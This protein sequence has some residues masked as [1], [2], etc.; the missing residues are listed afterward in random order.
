MQKR[1]KGRPGHPVTYE[2]VQYAS[3]TEAAKAIGIN[4]HTL[5]YRLDRIE[6]LKRDAVERP[7][8]QKPRAFSLMGVEFE[9]NKDCAV[10][11]GIGIQEVPILKRCHQR[12]RE[13]KARD[14]A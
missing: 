2:G 7:S 6:R 8:M 13:F 4:M 5:V 3:I 10:K 14:L 9:N 1:G 12:L 11:L